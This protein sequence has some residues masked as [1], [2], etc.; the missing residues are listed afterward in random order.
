MNADTR[1]LTHLET[2]PLVA[3]LR[4]LTPAEAPAVGEA[5]I[6]AGFTIIEVPLNSP[7]PFE[8]IATLVKRFGDH[9]MIGAGTVI[10]P[11]DVGRLRD[12]GAQLV[13]SPHTDPAL[14]KTSVDAGL[15]TVPGYQSATEAFAAL[16]AGATAL[17]LFPADALGNNLLAAHRAVLPPATRILAVGGITPDSMARWRGAGA[18]GFGLGSSLYRPNK[19]VAEIIRDAKAFIRAVKDLP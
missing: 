15:A 11:D 9:A 12:A 5:L 8:S 2:C 4:G 1:F 14:I 7:A 6:D 3:I 18:D 13:I 10:S 17:K 16:A 19:P